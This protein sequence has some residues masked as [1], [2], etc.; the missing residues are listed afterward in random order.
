MDTFSLIFSTVPICINDFAIER[1][2]IECM[3]KNCKMVFECKLFPIEIICAYKVCA[4]FVQCSKIMVSKKYVYKF[5]WFKREMISSA[6]SD[7][8]FSL[9]IIFTS[10]GS[11]LPWADFHIASGTADGISCCSQGFFSQQ[12][13]PAD[14]WDLVHHLGHLVRAEN[15]SHCQTSLIFHCAR[16]LHLKYLQNSCQ[17]WSRF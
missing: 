6:F 12:A 13:I 15:V 16:L 2:S 14:I 1:G 3:K 5:N 8:Q 4:E 7:R 11:L 17:R 9:G 10:G